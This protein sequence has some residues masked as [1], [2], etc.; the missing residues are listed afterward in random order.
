MLLILFVLM[1]ILLSVGL[2]IYLVEQENRNPVESRLIVAEVE[3]V[4]EETYDSETGGRIIRRFQLKQE[5][6]RL[7][8]RISP[9]KPQ[10]LTQLQ[11]GHTYELSITQ[12]AIRCHIQEAVEIDD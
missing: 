6:D 12:S 5:T 10:L 4:W 7:T 3:K 8:C 1:L 2:P 9:F 11:V